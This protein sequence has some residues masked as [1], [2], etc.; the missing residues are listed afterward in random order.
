MARI[1]GNKESSFTRM[2]DADVGLESE[3]TSQGRMYGRT[4]TWR[5][6]LLYHT[7]F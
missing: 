7:Q 3:K 2:S 5:W 1:E 6:L 4:C